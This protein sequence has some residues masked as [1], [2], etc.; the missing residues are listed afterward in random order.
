MPLLEFFSSSDYKDHKEYRKDHL[1]IGDGAS[2]ILLNCTIP[3]DSAF[4]TRSTQK[5]ECYPF[6]LPEYN[7]VTVKF[8]NCQFSVLFLLFPFAVPV[9]RKQ[10]C[11]DF[12]QVTVSMP[13]HL[14]A[15]YPNRASLIKKIIN[16]L[17]Q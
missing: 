14:F 11:F 16:C 6:Y 15:I 2:H 17:L 4:I 10:L 12:L 5:V 3:S 8:E 13:C 9:S 1:N 7:Q